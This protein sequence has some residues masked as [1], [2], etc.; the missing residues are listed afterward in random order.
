MKT[1]KRGKDKEACV[2]LK[3]GKPSTEL[4]KENCLKLIH[5][6]LKLCVIKW[7]D[8]DWQRELV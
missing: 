8:K 2:L 5:Y 1:H 6:L 4:W 3:W 7:T